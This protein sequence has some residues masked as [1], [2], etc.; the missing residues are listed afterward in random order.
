MA[1]RVALEI[2]A[3]LLRRDALLGSVTSAIGPTA[4]SYTL[5]AQLSCDQVCIDLQWLLYS[6]ESD[7]RTTVLNAA[8]NRNGPYAED[9]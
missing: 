6:T 9:Q 4:T 1:K 7:S 2:Y 8:E 3:A 5:I